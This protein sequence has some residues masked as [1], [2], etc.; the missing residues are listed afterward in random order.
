MNKHRPISSL[1]LGHHFWAAK[2]SCQAQ[3]MNQAQSK[4]TQLGNQL[5]AS[6]IAALCSV[7]WNKKP[8]SPCPKLAVW[9]GGMDLLGGTSP[10]WFQQ[11]TAVQIQT[12][13]IY[14]PT[15]SGF[16]RHG[17]QKASAP[18]TR[19]KWSESARSGWVR[20]HELGQTRGVGKPPKKDKPTTKETF[21]P[22][23]A[24]TVFL[25]AFRFLG[26]CSWLFVCFFGCV[27]ALWKCWAS[28]AACCAV[29]A[30]QDE[31][32]G[33]AQHLQ[34]LPKAAT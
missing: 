21:R 15:F 27:V 13:Q 2:P 9:F 34:L 11:N 28:C 3:G 30:N 29:L 17:K 22:W 23:W 14:I 10:I 7:S 1:Q 20:K 5:F 19:D 6:S 12:I 18:C 16:K 25:L 4:N 33:N 32:L 8:K 31:S 24:R 26:A